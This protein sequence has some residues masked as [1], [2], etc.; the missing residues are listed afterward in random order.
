MMWHQVQE[1]KDERR[2]EER[3]GEKKPSRR[4][5]GDKVNTRAVRKTRGV[6]EMR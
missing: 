6:L 4:I 5:S 1:E 2:L 3:E